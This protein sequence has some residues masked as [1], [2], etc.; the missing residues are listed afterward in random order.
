VSSTLYGLTEDKINKSSGNLDMVCR[1][2]WLGKFFFPFLFISLSIYEIIGLAQDSLTFQFMVLFD[3]FMLC[4][5]II[6]LYFM[7]FMLTVRYEISYEELIIQSFIIRKKSYPFTDILFIEEK[8]VFSKFSN[9]SIGPDF[10]TL[11]LKNGKQSLLVV[12]LNNL[13]LFNY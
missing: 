6:I 10:D 7:L 3:W 9:S 13:N 11:H 8:G 1:L 5:G 4:L 12:F 2:H